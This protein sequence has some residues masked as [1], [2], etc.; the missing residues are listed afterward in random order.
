MLATAKHFA[1]DG[2]TSYGTGEGDYT[3][4]QGI[5]EV[6]HGE[7]ARLALAPY[8]PAVRKHHVGAVMPSFSSVDWTEDG[9]GNPVKMH[10]NQE[11]ITGVLKGQL[12]FDGLVISDWRGIRQ[13]PGTYRDQ[14]EDLGQR[15]RSTCSW[16]P[17][18]A[19]RRVGRTSSRPSPSWWGPVRSR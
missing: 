13:I 14:V 12:G 8:R 17:T 5:D 1:G 15:G 10:A 2:L 3:V 4:D 16:S 11:L 18:A 19:T 9:L 6:S 7:F